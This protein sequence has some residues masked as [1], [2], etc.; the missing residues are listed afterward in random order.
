MQ[1]EPADELVRTEGHRLGHAARSVVFPGEADFAVGERKQ[2]AVGHGDAVSVAAEISQHLL[3][4]AE[5]CLGVDHP[6]EAP[7]FAET[8]RERLWFG[9]V[10]ELAE[11]PRLA[12]VEGVLQLPQEQP[13]E[14]REST[15]TGRKKP[16]RQATQ[17]VPSSEGPP[18]GTTQWTCG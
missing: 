17:W 16:G 14:S 13:A 5:R 11:E 15:R 6:I 18:P 10:D 3:G 4:S 8:A 1:Q 9:K 2:P 12:G 7:K